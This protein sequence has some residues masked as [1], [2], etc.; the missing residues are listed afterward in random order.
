M[1]LRKSCKESNYGFG[2][3]VTR[4]LM[5][6]FAITIVLMTIPLSFLFRGACGDAFA[7]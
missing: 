1:M 2:M 4:R 3:I 5:T 6:A 7:R